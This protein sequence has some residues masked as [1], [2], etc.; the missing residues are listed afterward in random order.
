MWFY[1]LI[2][3]L[4]DKIIFKAMNLKELEGCSKKSGPMIEL[5]APQPLGVE[6][7]RKTKQQSLSKKVTRRQRKDQNGM[8]IQAFQ[9]PRNDQLCQM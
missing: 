6:Q 8:E 4:T 5:C 9:R 2:L 1:I 7:K 3:I